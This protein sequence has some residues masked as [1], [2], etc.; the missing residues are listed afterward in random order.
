MKYLAQTV[1]IFTIAAAPALSIA[2]SNGPVTAEQVRAE[3]V[4][5]EQAGYHVGDGDNASYPA[6]IQA[7]EARVAA[8]NGGSSYGGTVSGTSASGAP[9]PA[10]TGLKPV[11]FGQ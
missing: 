5:L 3:L 6:D 9:A 8:Q 7:A 1:V 11:Y 10:I 2:Q 4:Q